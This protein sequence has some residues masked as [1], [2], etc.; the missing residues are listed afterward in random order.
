VLPQSSS[1]V[2]ASSYVASAITLP[3]A[4]QDDT[5]T[6]FV[7]AVTRPAGP[8]THFQVYFHPQICSFIATLDR[9]GIDG[10]LTLAN[11]LVPTPTPASSG[12]PITQQAVRGSGRRGDRRGERRGRSSSS[13]GLCSI[14]LESSST[15]FSWWPRLSAA[16]ASAT[17][18]WFHYIF[19]PPRRRRRWAFLEFKPF[20]DVKKRRRRSTI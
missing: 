9:L 17:R 20:F 6:Y 12:R 1:Y 2:Q 16:S 13:P 11:Q 4:Y 5:R 3:L 15:F 18:D 14:W 8:M 7:T 19:I 10:L